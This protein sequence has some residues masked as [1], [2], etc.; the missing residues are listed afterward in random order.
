[1]HTFRVNILGYDFFFF[2]R[3]YSLLFPQRF[4]AIT[5]NLKSAILVYHG[6]SYEKNCYERLIFSHIR[7]QRECFMKS[8]LKGDIW[9]NKDKSTFL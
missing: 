8:M 6:I 9:L 2:T 4:E 7:G 1:M 5:N 3:T